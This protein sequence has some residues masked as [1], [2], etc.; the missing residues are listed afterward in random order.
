MS[1]Q[2]KKSSQPNKKIVIC[3]S[4]VIIMMAIFKPTIMFKKKYSFG[5]LIVH[6]SV[7]NEIERWQRSGSRKLAKFGEGLLK[8]ALKYCYQFQGAIKEPAEA[9]KTKS[10]GIFSAIENRPSANQKGAPTSSTDK[11]LLL[12][13]KKNDAK[14][15]TQEHTLQL[16]GARVLGKDGILSFEDLSID[17]FAQGHM[18]KKIIEDG[19]D[20]LQRMG[21]SLRADGRR[22]ILAAI[23]VS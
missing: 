2:P 7:I 11:Y 23:G 4:N 12:L 22:K 1:Q 14:L 8:D 20:A 15:A 6:Q 3:D 5:D 18:D 10:F 13:A 17:L 16:L 19:I 9:E 21:E